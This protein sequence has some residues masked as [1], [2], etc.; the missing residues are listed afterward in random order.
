MKAIMLGGACD[1][2]GNTEQYLPLEDSPSTRQGFGRFC[3]CNALKLTGNCTTNV[4]VGV[5]SG[6]VRSDVSCLKMCGLQHFLGHRGCHPR[7]PCLR[8]TTLF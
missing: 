8:H 2:Q 3:L 1:M 7:L 6:S 4:Q 5:A